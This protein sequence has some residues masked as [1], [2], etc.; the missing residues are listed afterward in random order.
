M[1]HTSLIG[2][3]MKSLVK[4]STPFVHLAT[5]AYLCRREQPVWNRG[6]RAEPHTRMI[7]GRRGAVACSPHPRRTASSF[8]SSHRSRFL[9]RSL[10]ACQRRL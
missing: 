2:T 9:G 3:K 4:R 10:K 7:K 6:A 5:L 8:S 1:F